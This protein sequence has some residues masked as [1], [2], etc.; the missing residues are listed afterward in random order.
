MA[1]TTTV[2][3]LAV[4]LVCRSFHCVVRLH[5]DEPLLY[6]GKLWTYLVGDQKQIKET[7][8]KN[9]LIL[10]AIRS[11]GPKTRAQQIRVQAQRSHRFSCRFEGLQSF[12]LP[13]SATHR[14][15]V[16]MIRVELAV[17]II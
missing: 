6:S 11:G 15:L 4:G 14:L 3:G 16:P 8:E 13:K 10:S 9:F 12:P 17:V 2:L 7:N 1:V 5:S